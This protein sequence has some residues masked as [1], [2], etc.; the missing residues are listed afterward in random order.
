V[1]QFPQGGVE[2]GTSL[3]ENAL[4]EAQE[5]LGVDGSLL[6]VLKLLKSTHEY[7]FSNIPHYAVGKWRGQSQRFF[8]LEFLGSD[9]DIN[10]NLFSPEFEAF[11]WCTS[12]QVRELA[13]KKRLPG[14]AQPLQEVE[15]FLLD[16]S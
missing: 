10:L 4:R 8:L 2:A 6:R 3:E 5:E 9:S 12:S 15:Q 1:W 14:Y 16:K 7:E 13:E 11:R